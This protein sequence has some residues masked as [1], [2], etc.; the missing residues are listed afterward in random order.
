M[1]ECFGYVRVSTVKQ[2]EGVSLETQ[3]EAILG[4]AARNE[5]TITKWFEEKETAAKSGR[6]VFGA[7]LKEL[8][9]RAASGVV[10]HKIDRSARN[11]AD[12]AKIGE[13]ADAGIDVHFA[14]ESLDFRS[15]GGRLSADIQ[16]VIAA[17]YIRNLR[18][19][20]I[21]GING[22]LKQGLYPFGAPIGYLN[23]GGGKPKTPDPD[24]ASLIQEAFEL[25]ASGQHS[26][27]SLTAE[28]A[29]RGLRSWRGKPLGKSG[30]EVILANPFYCGLIRI[31]TTGATY[32]GIHE[33]LVSVRTFERV[34]DIRAG[35]SGKKMARHNHVYR[36]LFRCRLCRASM[37]PERQKGHVYYRCQT[38]VCAT[39]CIREEIL[40]ASIMALLTRMRLTDADV[41]T[42]I[43][44]A[45]RWCA[46]R[47]KED[48]SQSA[49]LQL[50][51]IDSRLE[52]LT[53]VM[54]D[55]VIDQETYA[56]R[57]EAL[58][59]ERIRVEAILENARNKR[60]DAWHVEKFLE[61]I[62]SLVELYR[63][64]NPPEKRELVE[65]TTSNRMVAEKNI[66][67]EPSN[68]LTSAEGVLSVYWGAHRRP[69]SR[70]SRQVREQQIPKLI[71]LARSEKVLEAIQACGKLLPQSGT[72]SRKEMS[73]DSPDA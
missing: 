50:A 52:R 53:D 21:K 1:K 14:T 19:E 9:K 7:M 26:L 46:A 15:R 36:G 29:R 49:R 43:T 58:L 33:P 63:I 28:M 57:K 31:K 71:E 27:R 67:V 48:G 72:G 47:A 37:I 69:K 56:K 73:G 61:L 22:R 6:P 32:Q 45:E 24:R 59:L 8:R 25:Y 5:I 38:Q 34:Q 16:A 20:T 40:E 2:G 65:I 10:M 30:I 4:F 62:K 3:K 41:K 35:K 68:W 44:D 18:E 55:G 11:F 70:S 51:Q 54:L 13:L 42:L 17:D 39:K 66:S 60:S 12:W 23:N 64:A